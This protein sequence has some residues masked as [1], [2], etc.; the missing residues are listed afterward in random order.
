MVGL[1]H[2]AEPVPA[3]NQVLKRGL[4]LLRRQPDESL[5]VLVGQARRLNDGC[6][7]EI[8]VGVPSELGEV[9]GAEAVSRQFLAEEADDLDL[10]NCG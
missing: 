8:R 2:L 1:G 7:G 6:V 10:G 5:L 4:G 3:R 9:V